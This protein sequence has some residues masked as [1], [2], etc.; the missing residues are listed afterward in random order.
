MEYYNCADCLKLNVI[1]KLLH[2]VATKI[3]EN[4]AM[5]ASDSSLVHDL[6]CTFCTSTTA[7]LTSSFIDDLEGNRDCVSVDTQ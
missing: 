3:G 6:A 2:A 4:A 1:A 5:S 7:L